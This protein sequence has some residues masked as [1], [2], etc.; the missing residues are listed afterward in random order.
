MPF[1]EVKPIY[2]QKMNLQRLERQIL[3]EMKQEAR[4]QARELKKVVAGWEGEK[5]TFE[6]VVSATGDSVT[7]A[8]RLT[9]SRK[10]IQKFGW[11]DKGTRIRWA[12]I[13]NGRAVIRGRRAMQRRN[14]R[15][16]PGIK[17]RRWT[18]NLQRSRGPRFTRR[19]QAANTKGVRGLYG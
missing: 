11:L 2:A 6:G 8:V 17:A 7:A 9:G 14:I 18:E 16:R 5:P 1:A 10:G 15:P 19:L 3:D 12:I 13:I 4:D